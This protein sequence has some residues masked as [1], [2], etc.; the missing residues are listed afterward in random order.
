MLSGIWLVQAMTAA[1]IWL[2][3]SVNSLWQ[4]GLSVALIAG[5]GA[6]AAVWLS[7]SVR[8][9]RRILEARHAERLARKTAELSAE[10]A[11][12][13][14][15]DAERFAGLARK[16]GQ[17]RNGLLR[18]GLLTGGVVGICAAFLLAQVLVIGAIA[19]AFTAG[20]FA[21]YHVRGKARQKRIGLTELEA[22]MIEIGAL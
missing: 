4:V 7:G 18:T 9:Q 5:V 10:L 11:R 15:A 16:A 17:A 19:A 6:L 1:L 2:T 12:Q 22:P 20:G 14:S 8:D 3:V 21:G 13:K